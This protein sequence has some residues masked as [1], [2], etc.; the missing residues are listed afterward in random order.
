MRPGLE[1]F[2]EEEIIHIGEEISDVLLYLIR[3]SDR[4]R[5]DMVSAV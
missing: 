4:C 2:S 3:F 5:I 1:G